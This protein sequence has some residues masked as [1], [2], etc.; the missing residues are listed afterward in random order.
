MTV[1]TPTSCIGCG[2]D[3]PTGEAETV[4]DTEGTLYTRCADSRACIDRP[5]PDDVNRLLRRNANRRPAGALV[6]V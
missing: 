4:A 1:E 6:P 3:I 2:H 5:V